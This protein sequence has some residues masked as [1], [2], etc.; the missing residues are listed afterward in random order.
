M[1]HGWGIWKIMQT[2]FKRANEAIYLYIWST[3]A[4]CKLNDVCIGFWRILLFNVRS[5]I[6]ESI[7]K[8]FDETDV[9][10]ANMRLQKHWGSTAKVD[11][12]SLEGKKINVITKL[13][14][15][16]FPKKQ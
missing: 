1:I 12:L 11:W 8:Q 10:M 2:R 16:Y 3:S 9:T 4:I 14:R 5:N 6:V 7:W 15:F 13:F